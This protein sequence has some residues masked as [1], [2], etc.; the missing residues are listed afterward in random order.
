MRTSFRELERRLGYSFEDGS[1]LQQALTTE[2]ADPEFNYEKL[3]FNGDAVIYL[4]MTDMLLESYPGAREGDLTTLRN[5]LISTEYLAGV[6]RSLGLN[7]WIFMAPHE[8]VKTSTLTDVLEAIT[9]A[10]YR[11]GGF[12][13]AHEFIKR[14]FEGKL[15]EVKREGARDYKTSLQEKAQ[16]RLRATPVYEWLGEGTRGHESVV[17]IAGREY[18]RGVGASKKKAEQE[19]AKI[20]LTRL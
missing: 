14:I 19:A 1:L 15:E 18:G 7:K 8:S 12:E 2:F 10:I 4:V 3:E 9:G 17:I 11:D 20:A 5:R 6:A 13:A 16:A